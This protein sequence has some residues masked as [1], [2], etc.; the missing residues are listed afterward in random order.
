MHQIIKRSCPPGLV[1]TLKFVVLTI[2]LPVALLTGSPA[3]AQQN[4]DSLLKP[5]TQLVYRLTINNKFYDVT[6]TI[7]S[8]TPVF[9][10]TWT[11]ADSANMSGELVHTINGITKGNIID[12]RF[13]PGSR[14]LSNKSTSLV[15]SKGLY[16]R[17]VN[18]RGKPARI[19]LSGADTSVYKMGTFEDAKELNVRINGSA[20]VINEE[21]VKS[22]AK[23]ARQFVTTGEEF[24]T[25]YN[26]PVLP[27]ILRL[28]INTGFSLEIIEI[29]T[30]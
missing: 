22:L 28:K 13:M 18:R 21:R 19:Y 16:R 6:A 3:A 20:A 10:F 8:L 1:A 25:F 15:L 17:L 12:H 5:G 26:S 30:P 27:I 11:M 7:K 29:R 2:M 23:L 9:V 24:F 4:L 14:T